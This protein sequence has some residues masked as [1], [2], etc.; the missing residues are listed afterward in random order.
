MS[1]NIYTLVLGGY[2]NGYSIIKELHEHHV[3][4]IVLFDYVKSIG[5]KSNKIKSFTQ[6]QKNSQSLKKA[7]FELKEECDYIIIYPT[8]DLQIEFL[9][10]IYEDIEEFCFIPF[11]KDTIIASLDKYTQY[12]FCEQYNVPY[13]KTNNITSVNEIDVIATMLFP[14]LVKPTKRYDK[15]TGVFRSMLVKSQDDLKVKKDKLIKLINKGVEFIASEYIPGDDTNI[16]AYVGYRDKKGNIL[17]EWIGKKLTQHPD[18]FGVFS[19]AVNTAPEVV[20]E[21]GRTLLN[22]MNLYGI[23]EPEFKYDE[24]DG[25]Y[26]LMEINLRSMMWH[27]LGNLSG[28]HLQY[29]QY[30]NALGK[31]TKQEEQNITGDV[32]FVYMKH[33]ISNLIF[34]RNYWKHFKNNVFKG[35]KRYFAVYDKT[36][37]KPFLFDIIGLIRLLLA[38][39][40]R[41][42]KTE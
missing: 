41:L 19:S 34:R 39:C 3:R 23:T 40:R 4:N 8:D 33:E 7:I 32:H 42:L 11:N 9:Y 29:T 36:D 17:N 26:K 24:R 25:K 12:S 16:Y 6:I 28:V 13:P 21:Q 2:V 35:E 1:K 22:S 18:K 10:D 31:D 14:V 15:S 20:R 27:R 38:R 30:L 37:V 5:S